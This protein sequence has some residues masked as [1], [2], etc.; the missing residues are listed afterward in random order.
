ML[1]LALLKTLKA[2]RKKFP[3]RFKIPLGK[4]MFSEKGPHFRALAKFLGCPLVQFFSL[5][6]MEPLG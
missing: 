5:L 1:T 6:R 3:G 4:V 2:A